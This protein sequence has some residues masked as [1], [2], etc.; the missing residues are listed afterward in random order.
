MRPLRRMRSLANNPLKLQSWTVLTAIQTDKLVST[1][2][3]MPTPVPQSS[4]PWPNQKR[5]KLFMNLSRS[6]ARGASGFR[7]EAP[8]TILE[9]KE[10]YGELRQRRRPSARAGGFLG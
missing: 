6:L 8:V 5:E 1:G 7:G 3:P 10:A 2:I 9:S 4:V